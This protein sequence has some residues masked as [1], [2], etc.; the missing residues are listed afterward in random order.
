MEESGLNPVRDPI[1]LV[2]SKGEPI[3]VEIHN[4]SPSKVLA[5]LKYVPKKAKN[6]KALLRRYML[7][8]NHG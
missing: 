6:V 1:N 8:Q 4:I 3:Y 5:Y 7:Y 2:N